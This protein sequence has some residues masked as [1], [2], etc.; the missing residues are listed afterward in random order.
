MEIFRFL[1]AA[2]REGYYSPQISYTGHLEFGIVITKTITWPPSFKIITTCYWSPCNYILGIE[3]TLWWLKMLKAYIQSYTQNVVFMMSDD[4][5]ILHNLDFHAH[6]SF[7]IGY[8]YGDNPLSYIAYYL[9]WKSFAVVHIFTFIPKNLL[10]LPAF[11]RLHNIH[12]YSIHEK[13][14]W[15]Q[16]NPQKTW[17]L[18]TANDKQYKYMVYLQYLVFRY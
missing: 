12:M 8:L 2:R 4:N 16:S 10:R 5:L 18:F 13:R 17:N 9:R 15:L 3:P 14:S 7:I 6:I 1:E 11:I